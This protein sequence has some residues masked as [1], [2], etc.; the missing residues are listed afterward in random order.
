[1]ISFYCNQSCSR[2]RSLAI[3]ALFGY[4]IL[5]EREA[6][7]PF[8]EKQLESC[9]VVAKI[10]GTLATT[11]DLFTQDDKASWAAADATFWAYYWKRLE[12]FEDQPLGGRVVQFGQLLQKAEVVFHATKDFSD[13][14]SVRYTNCFAATCA[15]LRTHL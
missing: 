15:L 14:Q 8:L 11:R 3:F 4:L 13:P 10:A 7:L 12:V 1:V 5:A 6:R 9:S 2:W